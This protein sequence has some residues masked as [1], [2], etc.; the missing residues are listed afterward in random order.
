[1]A[2]D[3]SMDEKTAWDTNVEGAKNILDWCEGLKKLDKL[4]YF[5]TCL[6]AGLRTGLILESEL[7]YGQGFKNNFEASMFEAEVLVRRRAASLPTIVFRP[8]IMVGDSRTGQTDRLDGPYPLIRF[9]ARQRRDGRL[10]LLQNLPLPSLGQGSAYLNLAPVDYVVD[11][12]WA[13]AAQPKALGKTFALVDPDP[14]TAREFY[15]ELLRRFGLGKTLGALP[16]TFVRA[17]TVAPGL[18]EWLDIPETLF[19][20]VNHYTVFDARNTQAALKGTDIVCP[21]VSAYLDNLID[22]VAA[23]VDAEGP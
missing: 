12:A 18:A 5:S 3:F 1:M 11:A 22:F 20:Y 10:K 6:N 16:L 17:L 7:E 15:N 14:P 21:P 2:D 19:D 9:L 23:Q 13:I 4:V 8:S